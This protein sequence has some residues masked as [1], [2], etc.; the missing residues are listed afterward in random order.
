MRLA[1]FGFGVLSVLACASCSG[2]RSSIEIEDARSSWVNLSA[3]RHIYVDIDVLAHDQLGGSIGP[4]C[5]TLVIPFQSNV[6]VCDD[7]L[8]DGD[9]KT[10]RV[11]SGGDVTDGVKI[12][13][14]LGNAGVNIGRD[15]IGPVASP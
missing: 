6:R 10:V 4:Y 14:I 11:E 5:A 3:N 8:S 2:S 7:D 13:V 1:R 12:G 15:L 9:R